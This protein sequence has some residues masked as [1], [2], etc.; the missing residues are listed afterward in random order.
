MRELV[1]LVLAVV[2]L[3]RVLRCVGD[4][5]ERLAQERDAALGVGAG[6]LEQLEQLGVWGA[7]AHEA[8]RP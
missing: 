1:A 5:G 2:D 6:S 3:V 7:G 4:G 8:P